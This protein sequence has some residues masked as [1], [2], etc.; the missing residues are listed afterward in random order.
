MSAFLLLT[1][2]APRTVLAVG[3]HCGDMELTA[4][5]VLARHARRGDHVVILHLTLGEGGNPKIAVSACTAQN[6]CEGV[7]AARTVG[8]G[9]LFGP[10]LTRRTWS[11]T[12]GASRRA[13]NRER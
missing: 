12:L 5:T 3:A 7:A 2:L 10:Y 1:L 11:A 4:G 13:V 8:A 6:R 9:A